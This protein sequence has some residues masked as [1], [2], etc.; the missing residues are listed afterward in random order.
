MAR[1]RNLYWHVPVWDPNNQPNGSAGV[2]NIGADI[3]VALV[4]AEFAA[5]GDPGQD[6]YVVER[7]IGQY[8]L[9][10]AA[11]GAETGSRLVHH[12]VYVADSDQSSIALRN[13]NT[14]DDADSSFLWHL[15]E[16]FDG[17]S[18]GLEWGSWRKGGD[19]DTQVAFQNGRLGSV[20]IKVGRRVEEGSTLIWHTQLDTTALTNDTWFLQMWMRCLIREG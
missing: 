12:R 5:P 4:D 16:P 18:V 14:Q 20:D 2:G 10:T 11:S 9:T 6:N 15:V 19:T 3:V 17:N 13:L 1:S 7:I 8:L